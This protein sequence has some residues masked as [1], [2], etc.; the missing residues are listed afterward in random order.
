L[1]SLLAH[2]Q[3]HFSGVFYQHSTEI[4]LEKVTTDFRI[5]KS[6][7]Y[8]SFLI[9][10]GLQVAFDT[11]G[12]PVLD[13]FLHLAARPIYYPELIFYFISYFFITSLAGFFSSVPLWGKILIPPIPCLSLLCW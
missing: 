1:C 12:H 8:F 9:L 7:K 11:V 5:S 6:S 4:A 2:F 10:F 3:D 13:A